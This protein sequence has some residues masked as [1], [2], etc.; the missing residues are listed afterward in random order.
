MSAPLVTVYITN[1]NY[2]HF[3]KQAINSVLQQTYSP[4]EILII[5]D[6]STDNSKEVINL[7]ESLENITV[8]YQQNKGLNITN[9]IALRVSKGKYIV[10]LDADDY[11]TNDAIELMVEKLEQDENLGLV[12]PD[13]FYVDANG[14]IIGEHTRHDF[15]SEVSLFDQAAHGACTMIRSKFL[16]NLGGYNENFSCQDGYELWVKFISHYKVTNVSKPLFYYRQHGKNLTTN[17]K[18]LLRTRAAINKSIIKMQQKSIKALA[19]I[20]VR[21]NMDG[22]AFE[23]INDKTLLEIK[24]EQAFMAESVLSTVVVAENPVIGSFLEENLGHV[25]NLTFVQRPEELSRFNVSL[26][27]TARYVLSQTRHAAQF[28]ILSLLSVEFPFADEVN[29]DDAHNTLEVFGSDSLITVRPE[30]SSFYQHHGNGMVSI[31]QQDQV[32]KLERDAL[33]RNTGAITVTRVNKFLETGQIINGLV[34]HA[35]IDQKAAF[36]IKTAFDLS[37]AKMMST[38]EINL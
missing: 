28:E 32:P 23:K 3:I 15:D 31:L 37:M 13:Y 9:N 1:Y 8:I 16:R 19:L 38:E 4:I 20:P 18:R 26:S 27:E 25:P 35:F 6:G 34:G 5:D 21:G 22:I 12:F 7:Y 2:G 17:E 10:R 33:Y 14:K 11:F 29:I 24:V 30:L 36:G